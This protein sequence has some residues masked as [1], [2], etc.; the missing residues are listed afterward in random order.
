VID[1]AFDRVRH[2]PD[3]ERYRDSIRDLQQAFFDD[4][5]AIFL[6][7]SV[8]ARAINKRFLVPAEEGRDVLSTIRLWTPTGAARQA[9][10]N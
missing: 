3:E 5:P 6:A 7:W 1:T 4:P 9:S 10:R 2:A 8:R